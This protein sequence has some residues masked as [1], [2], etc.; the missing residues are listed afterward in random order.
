MKLFV[1]ALLLFLLVLTG[2][3]LF[4]WYRLHIKVN[5]NEENSNIDLPAGW[6][7]ETQFVTNSDGQKIAYWYFPV[8]NPKAVIILIHGYGIP[9]G[10]TQM[11]GHSDYLYD[12]GY[13]TVLLD[14]RGYGKSEGNKIT[15]GINEWKDVEAVFDYI[16]S[17]PENKNKKIGYLGISM[18]AA[19]AVLSAG[20]THKGDFVIASVPYANFDSMF[21]SQIKVAGLPQIIYPLLKVSALIEFGKGYERFSPIAVIKDIKVPI[22]LI[23]AKQDEELNYQDAKKLYDSAN[24]PK[25]YWEIDSH[26]DIFD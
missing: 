8:N 4:T 16:K 13:S 14:L 19:T 9:G 3:F 25:E 20:E 12:A 7:G 18:G 23:S 15:L 26:H 11:L 17:L 10:K 6:K 5:L 22:L 2:T 1:S 24:Q 21:H